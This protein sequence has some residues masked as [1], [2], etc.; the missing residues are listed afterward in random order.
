MEQAA[1]SPLAAW[2]G[3][4][5]I[6]GPAAGHRISLVRIGRAPILHRPKSN[7][8]PTISCDTRQSRSAASGS[9]AW[10]S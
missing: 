8:S 10:A 3:F 6:I 4:Y 9:T 2:R 7:R 1:L 5:G